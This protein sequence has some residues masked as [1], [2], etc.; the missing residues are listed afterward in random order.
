MARGFSARRT[1]CTMLGMRAPKS[2]KISFRRGSSSKAIVVTCR[3][4]ADAK[5]AMSMLGAEAVADGG[6]G[7][8]ARSKKPAKTPKK[9]SLPQTE[10]K[11]P[12]AKVTKRQAPVSRQRP[13]PKPIERG[14][15]PHFGAYTTEEMQQD[16]EEQLRRAE[17]NREF[18]G[19]QLESS[20]VHLTRWG[21]HLSD[22]IG[23]TQRQ[24]LFERHLSQFIVSSEFFGAPP[25]SEMKRLRNQLG[26][27]LEKP[28]RGEVRGSWSQ[29]DAENLVRLV[30]AEV[31]AMYAKAIANAR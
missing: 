20:Y 30:R 21:I 7:R 3:S 9:R 19:R 28:V 16:R 24:Q 4:K 26:S 31:P 12:V 13:A 23:N 14:V 25:S 15:R 10:P 17:A 6:P 29:S 11:K 1:S 18:H 2:C 22:V 8:S 27:H 5:K